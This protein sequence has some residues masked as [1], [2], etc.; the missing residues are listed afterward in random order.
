MAIIFAKSSG[1]NDDLWKVTDQ[2]LSMVMKDTDTEKNKYEDYVNALFNV[3]KSA[4]FG[5]KTSSLTSF[6]DFQVTKEGAPLPLDEMQQGFS[7]L[8]IHEAFAK[9]FVCTL[10]MKEDNKI[11]D[12]KAEAANLVRAYKRTRAQL[13]SM[14]ITAG[15]TTFVYGGNTFDA[16]T[17]DGK[18]LFATDHPAIKSGASAQANL[19]S[20]A[21]GSDSVTL[22]LLANIGKNFLNQSGQIQGYEFDTIIIPNNRPSLEDLVKRIIGSQQ[23]VNSP[24]NDINTNLNKWKL[25][26]DPLW[27]AASGTSPYIIMS[28]EANKEL[29]ANLFYDRVELEVRNWVDED[30]RNLCWSGRGRMSAGARDWRHVIMGGVSGGATASE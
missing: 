29:M 16:T 6:G 20:N 27:V 15:A 14:F 30:T 23:I 9:K 22:N 19:F 24:N 12:M 7:K 11:D 25:I 3:K 5:E 10:E 8:I 28:S 2:A 21:F 13:A 18:A 26:V 17:A 1:K 4:S